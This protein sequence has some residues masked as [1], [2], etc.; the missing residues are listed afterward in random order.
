[1]SFT[2]TIEDIKENFIRRHMYVIGTRFAS[3]P[4]VCIRQ[5][6]HLNNDYLYRECNI[7]TC[8]RQ[9]SIF[10]LLECLSYSKY[11]YKASN[12]G[13]VLIKGNL[14]NTDTYC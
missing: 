6:H 11:S 13:V 14:S 7:H 1:M 4:N 3:L 8:Y 9:L 10:Y 5:R 12:I 2:T